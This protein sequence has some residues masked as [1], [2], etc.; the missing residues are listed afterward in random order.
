[1]ASGGRLPSVSNFSR[2]SVV[3]FKYEGNDWMCRR[4]WKST[5]CEIFSVGAL[6]ADTIR[7]PGLPGL[8]ILSKR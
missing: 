1:M 6:Q 7:L 4:S 3:S 8:Y 2:K 5:N